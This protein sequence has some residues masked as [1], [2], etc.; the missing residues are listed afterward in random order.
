M[1]AEIISVG[2]ELLLGEI[3]DT[4]AVFLSQELAAL[5][6]ELYHRTTVGDNARRLQEVITTALA[7][8][9][10]VITIGGLGPTA[11]DLT[12][13]TVAAVLGLPL[14]LD[15]PS[16]ARIEAYFARIGRPMT[17]NNYKQALIPEGG[18]ALPN[19]NGTAPGV[20]V[21][22]EGKWVVCLPGPPRELRPMFHDYVR[23][24]LAAASRGVI[25]SRVLRLC[26]IGESALV[27]TIADLLANQTN[28]TLAP[29]A[30]EGE[31]RL[32]ITAAAATVAAADAAIAELEQKLRVR[33]G[34]AI[35]G[36][37]DDTLEAIVVGLLQQ[38]GETLAVAESCTG[39]LLANRITDVPGAS[40]VFER[41]VVAYS[42]R[43]KTELLGIPAPVIQRAGAVSSEVATLM[44]RGIRE[45]TESDWGIGITGIAG[46]GGGTAEKPVGLV[47][48]AL[49]GPGTNL[50]R[51]A[52]FA[53]DRQQIKRRT[54]QAVLD[55]FRRTLQSL[56]GKMLSKTD[57]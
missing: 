47:Y 22:K 41:G 35:Y 29:L 26:G 20:S 54:T 23:P 18:E 37:D 49:A 21:R 6:I 3:V 53:G 30:T 32:R 36:V 39:G 42:N 1:R 8:A 34:P 27:E 14:V 12:K 43:A 25:R 45:R 13:E 51:E 15:R 11:D 10:L 56:D 5:G 44:A 38:R 2:T 9:D 52:R 55:L 33:L 50:V 40:A 7:R 17:E 57:A 4:N 46:P 19:R 28:P 31:V 48:F 16:L 24:Q